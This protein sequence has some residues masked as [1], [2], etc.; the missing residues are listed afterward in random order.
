MADLLFV[1]Y[2]NLCRSPLAEYLARELLAKT[3]PTGTPLTVAS[4]GTHAVPGRSMHPHAA[5]VIIERGGDPTL[6]RSRPLVRAELTA[7]SLVLT[8]SRRQRAACV[9]LAPATINRTFTLRQFSRLT[10]A[11]AVPMASLATGSPPMTLSALVAAVLQVRGQLQPV[12][13]EADDLPDPIGGPLSGF[14]DC[15]RQ[16][17]AALT[18]IVPLIVGSG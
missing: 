16:V 14:Q 15:A 2:A 7:A 18:E 13:P 6:F 17:E 1:C 3:G 4:A 11:R 9:E 5:H 10:A 12:R 8:A